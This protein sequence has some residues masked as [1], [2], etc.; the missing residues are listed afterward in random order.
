[1]RSHNILYIASPNT[2]KW[3]I[4]GLGHT[5]LGWTNLWPHFNRQLSCGKCPKPVTI[6]FSLPKRPK[7]NSSLYI[8]HI[9][10]VILF[11]AIW[12]RF[13]TKCSGC[14]E[15]IS[16]QDLV[17]RAGDR[18]YHVSCFTCIVC[19][20]PLSTGEELYVLDENRFICKD[21]F[22]NSN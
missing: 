15:G 16:P 14:G 11:N 2:K 20:K 17:R 12:R 3:M 4:T 13:G 19:R 22:L 1:M 7:N 8:I 6:Q 9:L 18:V 10:P 21:D 5:L